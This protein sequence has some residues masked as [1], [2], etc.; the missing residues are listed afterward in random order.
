GSVFGYAQFLGKDGEPIAPQGP[1]TLGFSWGEHE[2]LTPL[3]VREGRRPQSSGEVA[4][5][6]ATARAHGFSVGD[7]VTVLFHQVPSEEFEIVGIAGFG[8][9]DNLAGATLAAFDT[10]TAQRVLGA[11]GAFNTINVSAE[12]GVSIQELQ[13]RI[14]A[15]VP[16]GVQVIAGAAAAEEQAQ[17]IREGLSFFNTFLLVFAGVALFV[18]AF[19]IFNTFNIL[20]TQRTRELALLRALGASGGQV[21]RSVL[22]EALVVGLV[23]SLAGLGLGILVAVGLQAL[24]EALG[25]DLPSAGLQLLP[26]TVVVAL[27]VGVVVTVVASI[28]PARRAARVAPIAALRE[29]SVDQTTGLGRRA[30]IGLV[31]GL[32][33]VAALVAGLVLD[34]SNAISYVGLG[35][36]LVFIGVTALAPLFARPAARAIGAPLPALRGVPGKLG[37]ENAMRNPKRTSSTAAALMIGIALVSTFAIMGSSLKASVVRTVEE[38]YRSDFIVTATDGFSPFSPRIADAMRRRAEIASVSEIRWGQWRD[39]ATDQVLALR[40][41]DPATILEVATVDAVAGSIRDLRSGTVAV[42][43]EVASGRG[44]SVGDALEMEFAATGVRTFRVVAVYEVHEILGDY[45]VALGTH[46]DNFSQD[47]D[48]T[49]YARVAPGFSL[50]E[51]RRAVDETVAAFPNVRVQDQTEFKEEVGRQIDQVMNLLTSLLLLAILIALLGIVNTL[52]LSVLE[53][54]R[55]IGLLRAVG[56]SRKQT[57]SMIRWES[58]IIAVFGGVLGLLVGMLFGSILVT[59]LA[60]EGVTELVFPVGRLVVFLVAA[61]VAGVLAAVLPARR[62]ANLN[63]LQAISYE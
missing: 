61:A 41:V 29:T 14:S 63:V 36:G 1:P 39:P 53:R 11:E 48:Q 16:E 56:I 60:D 15:V 33:G 23:S 55:E 46:A 4:M 35:V 30:A 10:E 8:E 26:R 42:D 22:L 24:L 38:T 20:V 19:I 5:D 21:M 47:V 62:A 43:V 58:V 51:S 27:V 34:L 25:V 17:E 32:V 57:K 54:T 7:R 40:A 44:L 18:G 12:D 31:V 50:E 2:E 13:Q 52:A 59:A 9:A 45:A 37:R 28:F 6:A 49:V 3:V